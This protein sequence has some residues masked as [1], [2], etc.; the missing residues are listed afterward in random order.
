MVVTPYVGLKANEPLPSKQDVRLSFERVSADGK[1]AIFKLVA[2]PILHGPGTCLPS[3]SDCQ[4]IDLVVGQVEEL[5]YVEPNGQTV[6][7][8]L[9]VVSINK[10]VVRANTAQTKRSARAARAKQKAHAALLRRKAR[11]VRG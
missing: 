6:G 11:P 5:E 7:Y 1:G 2:A 9:R 4:S 8:A 10:V 3:T